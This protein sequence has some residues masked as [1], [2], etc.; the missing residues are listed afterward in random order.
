MSLVWEIELLKEILT[1]I[2]VVPQLKSVYLA[3]QSGVGTTTRLKLKRLD[4]G[5][6]QKLSEFPMRACV[7]TISFSTDYS[8]VLANSDRRIYL[9]CSKTLKELDRWESKVPSGMTSIVQVG[10]DV[11]MKSRIGKNVNLDSLDTMRLQRIAVGLGRPLFRD[12]NEDTFLACCE[13]D[14][15]VCRVNPTTGQVTKLFKGPPFNFCAVDYKSR[16]LCLSEGLP[17]NF[18]YISGRR[19]NTLRSIS[20]DKDLDQALLDSSFDRKSYIET[21]VPTVNNRVHLISLDASPSVHQI[22]LE[23]KVDGLSLSEGGE[24]VWLRPETERG[25]QEIRVISTRD[26]SEV[27][28][29]EF[30]NGEQ[31]CLDDAPTGLIFTSKWGTL[32][33]REYLLRCWQTS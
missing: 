4:I 16:R 14:G 12:L 13:V 26:A 8:T 21:P 15:T 27:E 25:N 18:L 24:V 9:L 10:R 31:V 6:G 29:F 33:E 17:A 1:D 2:L 30:P 3:D 7:N 20:C 5:S 22:D 23:F 32:N 28:R 11:A 19:D